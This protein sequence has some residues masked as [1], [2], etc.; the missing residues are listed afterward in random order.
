MRKGQKKRRSLYV[1]DAAMKVTLGLIQS[2]QRE[3]KTCAKCK[4]LNHFAKMC[5][6]TKTKENYSFK[7]RREKRYRG[8]ESVSQAVRD[9]AFGIQ[10]EMDVNTMYGRSIQSHGGGVELNLLID[11]G[12]ACSV[13]DEKTWKMC[14][15]KSIKCD[16]DKSVQKQIFAYGQNTGLG[17]LGEFECI[18][19]VGNKTRLQI[20]LS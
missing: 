11:S 20:L 6:S 14:K 18:I 1:L 13:I 9:Y 7:D 3:K 4:G 8:K 12:A 17:L 2:V 10:K 19:S 16:L 15:N 5:K